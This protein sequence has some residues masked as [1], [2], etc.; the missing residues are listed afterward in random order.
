MRCLLPKWGRF[1]CWVAVV[2]LLLVFGLAVSSAR[3]KSATFDEDA[4]IGKGAA[5]WFLHNYDLRLIHPALAPVI[6]TSLLWTEPE[7]ADAMDCARCEAGSA[8]G[9]GRELLFYRSYT[10]RTLFLVRL[11]TI[12]MLVI[13][14]ALVYR[15]GR[16]LYGWKGGLLALTVCAFE[17]N[18]LAHGRLFTLDLPAALF[19][20][21]SLYTS[22]RFWR[23]PGWRRLFSWGITLGLAGATRYTLGF[24][25]PVMVAMAF[26]SAVH[27]VGRATAWWGNAGR[28]MKWRQFAIAGGSLA[29]VALIA[30]LTI[31]GVYGFSFGP[32]SGWGV[33]LPAPVYFR[34]LGELLT[35]YQEKP[36]DAFLL[37]RHYTGGRW[38]YFLFTLAV[39]TPLPVLMLMGLAFVSFIRP[40]RAMFRD[41]PVWAGCVFYYALSLISRLNYG[42]R[43]LLPIL[44]LLAIGIGRLGP[45]LFD[46]SRLW[47]YAG[48]LLLV[49]L[50]SGT[51]WIHPHYL[52]YFNE[53]VGP[54]NG[55][56]VLVDSNV[57]WGQDLP[58]LE[59][60][61]TEHGIDSL[62][63]SWFGESRPSQYDIPYRFIPS[64]P[65]EL[66]DIYTRVYHPD[67]PPPGTYAISATNLQGLLFDDKDL[68]AWFFQR[69]PIAQPGY[70]I[71]VYEVPRLLD[72]EAPPVAVALGSKQIDQVPAA[73]FEEFWRTNDLQLRW[74][75]A[76]SS[77]VLPADGDVWYVL[78]AGAAS[79]PP[80]CPLWEGAETVAQVPPRDGSDQLAL[81]RVRVPPDVRETWLRDTALGSPLIL[82]DEAAFAPGEAPDLR[83]EI[84]PPLRFGDNL[85]MVGYRVLSGAFSPGLEWQLASYWRVVTPAGEQ[86]KL[87]AQVLDDAGNVRVQFDGL[88]IPVIGWQVGDILVQQHTLSLS[89]DLAPGRYWVQF[90]VYGAETKQ[91]LEVLEGGE[92]VGTRVLLPPMEVR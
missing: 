10:P 14:G 90:G 72:A 75:D 3:V 42:H 59:Q 80:P 43:Y 92:V 32:V 89:E 52:A 51:L 28:Q 29:L 58:A 53:L 57:D 35:L 46:R 86:L 38:Y 21:L 45:G 70:S 67:Y 74:F 9:C 1:H 49:W 7:F 71:L 54:R 27:S 56:R 81:Y 33:S 78:P 65:D 44:P 36:Q 82:S 87:F 50:V 66:S 4:Y 34:D 64:K 79:A 88:D 17:P 23:R 24:V 76:A 85:E 84:S 68:F 47:R 69:E 25:I 11:P 6:G 61:V 60:Y 40:H 91:R 22:W 39:K 5:I 8:R 77:C 19:A 63:L 62:Y 26:T 15:W 41:W 2:L 16:E 18:L 20:C 12:G 73:V 48:G 30:A 31:W 13:L 55:Y 37:G 83:R